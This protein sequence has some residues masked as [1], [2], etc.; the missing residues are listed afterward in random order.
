MGITCGATA[1]AAR[2]GLF[3]DR[4]HT[5]NGFEF[6]KERAGNYLGSQHYI[7]S[8]SAVSRRNRVTASGLAPL[9][10]SREYLKLVKRETPFD[11]DLYFAVYSK[12]R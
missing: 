7:C 8:S 4:E 2:A 9:T 3:Q 6:L 12:E 1:F 10:F 11:Q 5:S